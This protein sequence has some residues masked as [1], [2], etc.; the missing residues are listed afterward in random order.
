MFAEIAA[1]HE[2]LAGATGFSVVVKIHQMDYARGE[3]GIHPE[4]QAFKFDGADGHVIYEQELPIPC[5]ASKFA[6]RILPV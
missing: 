6:T 1:T 2:V 5:W 4:A 3:L